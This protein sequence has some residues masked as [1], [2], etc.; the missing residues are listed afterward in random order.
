MGEG[1]TWYSRGFFCSRGLRHQAPTPPRGKRSGQG[2]VAHLL[3]QGCKWRLRGLPVASEPVYFSLRGS[4]DTWWPWFAKTGVSFLLE[5]FS[6]E[7]DFPPHF[8]IAPK[9]IPRFSPFPGCKTRRDTGDGALDGCAS[10]CPASRRGF[11][12][13]GLGKG[14]DALC[15]G[16][17]RLEAGSHPLLPPQPHR[18]LCQGLAASPNQ[19]CRPG[20]KCADGERFVSR[21]GLGRGVPAALAVGGIGGGISSMEGFQGALRGRAQSESSAGGDVIPR[22]RGSSRG[23]EAAPMLHSRVL[24]AAALRRRARESCSRISTAGKKVCPFP[25][26]PAGPSPGPLRHLL[27]LP[28]CL[29]RP[30][31]RPGSGLA[32]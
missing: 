24:L 8:W 31:R 4:R 7:V 20:S 6:V 10:N 28:T 29:L 30:H 18:R 27:W 23:A 11:D 5:Q 17:S 25:A 26:S 22:A 19:N 14:R 15:L 1:R 3:S 21:K 16:T 9:P 12:T 32:G 13:P 2:S